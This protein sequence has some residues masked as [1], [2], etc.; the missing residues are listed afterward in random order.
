MMM[1][2]ME[3][4]KTLARICTPEAGTE[5]EV[6]LATVR[7][8][9]QKQGFSALAESPGLQHLFRFVLEQGC[10]GELSIMEPLYSFHENFVMARR[11]R[12]REHNFKD[13]CAVDEA[14]L[15]L[16]VL[17]SAYAVKRDKIRD[18]WIECFGP[19]HIALLM[20]P[21]NKAFLEK[22]VTAVKTFHRTYAALAAYT[23]VPKRH[24]ANLLGRLAIAL[25][26]LSLNLIIR[27]TSA[28]VELRLR[29]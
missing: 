6:A 29:S 15:R 27:D 2:E 13:V 25:G 1:H 23:H 9:L 18:T 16:V 19:S 21:K 28:C 22:L 4:I 12:F 10:H 7:E 20:K 3:T 8:K 17:Q 24:Q 5:H 11:R 14:W 26:Q